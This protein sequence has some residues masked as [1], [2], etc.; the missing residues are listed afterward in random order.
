MRFGFRVLYDAIMR[1]SQMRRA[2][3]LWFLPERDKTEEKAGF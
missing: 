2:S 1:F 3:S